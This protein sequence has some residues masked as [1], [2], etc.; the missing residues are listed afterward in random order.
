MR[1]FLFVFLLNYFLNKCEAFCECSDHKAVGLFLP[2]CKLFDK[3]FVCQHSM[4]S[5][6]PAPPICFPFFQPL[7]LFFIPLFYF[8]QGNEAKRNDGRARRNGG[9]HGTFTV[10]RQK[11][12]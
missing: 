10:R 12:D 6:W 2:L 7:Y 4:Y 8:S 5:P 9:E 11:E 1:Q 3:R